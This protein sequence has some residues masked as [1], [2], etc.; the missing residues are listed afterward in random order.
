VIGYIIYDR[1][2][3]L[4]PSM[5]S[6]KGDLPKVIEKLQQQ[7]DSCNYNMDVLFECLRM[8]TG[9]GKSEID[10]ANEIVKAKKGMA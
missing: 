10:K 5:E 1:D 4:N 2:F 7:I 8:S 3:D 9:I 6:A